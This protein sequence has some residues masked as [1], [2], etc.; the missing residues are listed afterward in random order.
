M[1]CLFAAHFM[2]VLL[3]VYVEFIFICDIFSALKLLIG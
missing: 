3:A 2:M 1:I